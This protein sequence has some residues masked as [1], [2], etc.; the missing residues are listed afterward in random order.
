LLAF[1]SVAVEL[2]L[3][4]ETN[5]AAVL[6]LSVAVDVSLTALANVCTAASASVAVAV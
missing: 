5:E 3:T 2:S 6:R 4:A 1:K